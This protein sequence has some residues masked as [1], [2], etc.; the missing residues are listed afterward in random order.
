MELKTN[1][2]S[3]I[4]GSFPHKDPKQAVDI[5][6]RYIDKI[7]A[8]PQLPKRSFRESMYSQFAGGLP[9]LMEDEAGKK[10]WLNTSEDVEPQLEKFYERIL[11]GD[12]E[13]FGIT[14][15]RSAGFYAF[16]DALSHKLPEGLIGVK[17]QVT[18]PVSFGLSVTDQN[19]KAILYDEQ[20]RP[21]LVK[22]LSMKAKWQIRRL[23]RI[24]DNVVI[25]IDEP[26]LVSIG[27]SFVS[28]NKEQVI[29]DLN[30]VADCI[31]EEGAISGIHCCGNTDW[32]LLTQTHTDIISFDA[33][34]YTESL[35]LYTDSLARFLK[36]GGIIAWGIVPTSEKIDSEDAN[37]LYQKLKKSLD[38][39][40]DKG[41]NKDL[42][43]KNA[44]ITPSCG[45]GTLS[46]KQAESCM[47]LLSELSSIASKSN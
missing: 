45:T 5:I 11:A 19:D 33:Y 9:C 3:T 10:V 44:L 4:I 18:G 28:L 17:G 32:S 23:K 7:P 12:V 25:F 24:H 2:D 22:T 38:L 20:I 27:S 39:L 30:E 43:Y 37:S 47:S 36:R 15:E 8:W 42:V 16:M 29:S 6:L 21:A 40:V 26:Y 31:K 34:D 41:I 35:V 1:F 46:E 14:P 13:Y